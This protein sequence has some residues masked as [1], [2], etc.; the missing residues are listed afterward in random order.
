MNVGKF[1]SDVAFTPAVK[2]IQEQRGSR[3]AYQRMEN[4][5]SWET[6]ITPTLQAFIVAQT[7]FFLATAN[8]DGQPYIQHRGGPAGFLHVLDEQT[9]G[10]ADFS[11]NRQFITTGNLQENRKA[12]LF[13]IDYA[14]RLRIKIWGEAWVSA[15]P[16]LIEQLMPASYRARAEQAM[17]FKVTAWDANCPQHIPQRFEAT[18]VIHALREKDQKIESLEKELARLRQQQP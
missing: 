1:S 12:H 6:R 17:L 7:S 10:F 9:L 4:E 16:Q 5:G 18:E 2:V 13:L 3:T 8:R 15:D 14:Q 11:G